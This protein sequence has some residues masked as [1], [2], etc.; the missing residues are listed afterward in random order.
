MNKRSAHFTGCSKLEK[1]PERPQLERGPAGRRGKTVTLENPTQNQTVNP[2]PPKKNI[3]YENH[4]ENMRRE[5][6]TGRG[7]GRGKCC[8]PE[9]QHEAVNLDQRSSCKH[10]AHCVR[11]QAVVVGSYGV[12]Q[13]K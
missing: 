1:R 11:A 12:Q 6:R 10:D 9:R 5:V 3:E 2:S 7:E 8:E 4:S 13:L